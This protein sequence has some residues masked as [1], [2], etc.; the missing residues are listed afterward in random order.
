MFNPILPGLFWRSSG[1]RGEWWEGRG[2]G[3]GSHLYNYPIHDCISLGTLPLHLKK[4]QIGC[5]LYDDERPKKRLTKLRT[6]T[7]QTCCEIMH[8]MPSM[9]NNTILDVR[10]IR[11]DRYLNKLLR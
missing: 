4:I 11:H 3:G 8:I 2:G 1:L 9:T 6:V 5:I 10:A 7:F